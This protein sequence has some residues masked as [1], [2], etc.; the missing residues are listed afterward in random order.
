MRVQV[1]L[2]AILFWT[3][4]RDAPP[5]R[6][7]Q[8]P[9]ATSAIVSP[10]P[11]GW[12]THVHGGAPG[13][14]DAIVDL[15]AAHAGIRF[16]GVE[17]SD[18]IV[19]AALA[20][21]LAGPDGSTLLAKYV[22][23][24]PGVCAVEPDDRPLAP[25]RVEPLGVVAL[26]HPGTGSVTLPPGT[27]VVAV[28]LRELPANVPITWL[29]EAIAPAIATPV[30]GARR[31]VRER[32]GMDDEVYA[33]PGASPYKSRITIVNDPEW[34]A[35]GPADLPLVLITGTSLA[36][37]AAALAGTL[38]L[39]GRAWIALVN[40]E[41]SAQIPYIQPSAIRPKSAP[42]RRI[43]AKPGNG[44]GSNARLA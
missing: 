11:T 37:Q 30:A 39:A 19:D 34:K 44:R 24:L 35:T 32:H 16:F 18:A 41:K 40:S 28:D 7:P 38:R 33:A 22:A 10:A 26:V 3:C 2:P 42:S 5:L 13:G 12:C 4:C 27:R 25:A 8:G 1:W 29:E 21:A 31:A 6:P 23:G 9:S 15:S 36:P 20:H 14:R 43:P 17:T